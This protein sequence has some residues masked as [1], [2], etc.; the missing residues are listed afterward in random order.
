LQAAKMGRQYE[1]LK[2]HKATQTQ[3]LPAEQWIIC[4]TKLGLQS[5]IIYKCNGICFAQS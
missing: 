4:E 3:D 2:V 5:K 1:G